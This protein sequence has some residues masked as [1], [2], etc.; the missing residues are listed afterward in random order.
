[1]H[2]RAR[3]GG[4]ADGRQQCLRHF[5]FIETGNGAE[6]LRDFLSEF[7]D[8]DRDGNDAAGGFGHGA[9]DIGGG[10]AVRHGHV[11]IHD[12]DVRIE[13]LDQT[14]SFGV[15]GGFTDQF[16]IVGGLEQA[17]KGAADRVKIVGDDNADGHGT[18]FCSKVRRLATIG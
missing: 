17:A 18:Q 13:L 14:E 2:G 8:P 4:G 11:E 10:H 12:Q 5:G 7:V 6:S 15:V 16:D 9:A 1:M 3:S